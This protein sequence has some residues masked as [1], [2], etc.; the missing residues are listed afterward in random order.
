METQAFTQ[1]T[2]DRFEK[3]DTDVE[4]LFFDECVKAKLNRSVMK[5]TKEETPFLKDATFI[6]KEAYNVLEPSFEELD[7]AEHLLN[8]PRIPIEFDQTLMY[9]PRNVEPL[10]T[11]STAD[12]IKTHAQQIVEKVR[13]QQKLKRKE[14]FSVWFKSKIKSFQKLGEN[15]MVSFGLITEEERKSHFANRLQQVTAIIEAHVKA[16]EE[17]KKMPLLGLKSALEVLYQQN[18]VLMK[19]ADEEQLVER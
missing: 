17:L 8:G 15:E 4:V 19:T 11:E 1:F 10:V 7:K 13:L 3:P 5:L 9:T 14:D 6:I 18:V 2:L 12:R 16:E